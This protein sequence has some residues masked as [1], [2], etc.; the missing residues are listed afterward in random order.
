MRIRTVL[1]LLLPAIIVAQPGD[2]WQQEVKYKMDIS[3]SSDNH[4]FKGNQELTYFNNSPDTIRK[5]Y[6]HLYFNAFQPGSMMDE[7]QRSL[8]DP[9]K[10]IGERILNL[11]PDEYGYHRINRLSQ[12]EKELAYVVEQT[13]LRAELAQPLAPGDSTVLNMKFESQV[14]VQIRRSGRNNAEGVDYTMT[15]WY[16]KL[17]AYDTEGWHP[18]FYIAREFYGDYGSF[19]VKID[20]DA[21]YAIGG[22]GVL[23]NENEIWRESKKGDDDG[24]TYLELK[25]AEGKRRLWHFKAEDVHDFAWAADPDY[26]RI[27]QEVS[28][29]FTINHYFLK[30][31]RKTWTRLPKYTAQFF[32]LMNKHF[33]VYPY[34]QF[35]VIQGGDGG[36]EYPMCTMLKG[37]G[38]LKGL[39]GVTVHESAHNWYYAVLGSN[40]QRYPWMDEGFTSFTEDEILK[41]MWRDSSENMHIQAYANYLFLVQQGEVE[42]L[43]TPADSYERNRTYGISAYSRGALFLNQLRYIIG[44]KDF[45]RGMLVY[46][47]RWKFKH[48]D[49]WDFIRVMEEVSDLE[50]DWYLEYWVYTTKTID[51]GIG[52]LTSEGNNG[53]RVRLERH[54]EMPMPLEVRV[55][56]TSGY[57]ETYFIPLSSMFG[58][59]DSKWVTSKAPWPWTHPTYDLVLPKKIGEIVSIDI[60][61][62][63]FMCDVNLENNSWPPEEEK[64]E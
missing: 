11:K 25:K 19:E 29:S 59:K 33:G 55:K 39:V 9:D 57:E 10:R 56:Y 52:E 34:P 43:S 62:K 6:Y 14:P 42:P 5:V 64:K 49:P 7:R 32:E 48:P 23:L 61:P 50:L 2:Y 38:N 37:S 3:F 60:D 46:Y 22:T 13:V 12:G 63:R 1:L 51:Y 45:N 47:D 18:D 41:V 27:R 16:P 35:S 36:M 24:N 20:I 28:E 44:E 40:E 54:G 4:Q 53:T 15:Q 8:P 17:A 31:Y 26:L 58:T 30:K 21:D